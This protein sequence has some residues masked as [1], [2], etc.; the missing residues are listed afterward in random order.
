MIQAVCVKTRCDGSNLCLLSQGDVEGVPQWLTPLKILL[1]KNLIGPMGQAKRKLLMNSFFCSFHGC[2]C[3][4]KICVCVCVCTRH[5][6]ALQSVKW[7]ICNYIM[8]L[9][10]Y[11][12]NFFLIHCTLLVSVTLKESNPCQSGAFLQIWMLTEAHQAHTPVSV[13]PL[14]FNISALSSDTLWHV[15]SAQ[16]MCVCTVVGFSVCDF[17]CDPFGSSYSVCVCV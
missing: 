14:S 10:P 4:I 12:V 11:L 16:H 7:E 13:P 9:W 1:D 8:A 3:M 17:V 2:L 6:I 5:N 15:H